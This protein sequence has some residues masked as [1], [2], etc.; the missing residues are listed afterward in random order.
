MGRRSSNATRA[1]PALTALALVATAGGIAGC[2][3]CSNGAKPTTD[4]AASSAS[5]AASV[6]ASA[7]WDGG[8]VNVTVLPAASIAK[9]VNPQNLPAYSGPTG[10]VEG[11][12][13]VIGDPPLATPDDF[14]K[15]PGAEQIWGHAFREG[16]PKSEGGPRPLADAVVAVTGYTGFYIPEKNEAKEVTIDGCGYTSRTVTT[17]LGQRVDVRNLAK[18]FWTPIL[19]PASRSVLRMA[20]PKGDPVA[21]YPKQP[22]HWFIVD[23]DRKY[24]IVDV[25]AFLHPLHT[26]TKLDGTYRIDGLP[27]GK[28]TV[29]TSHPRIA[30]DAKATIEVQAN[31]VARVDLQLV[32][33]TPDASA[34]EV[35]SGMNYPRVH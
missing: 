23:H 8:P 26:S 35:D 24:A 32:Y 15:C 9:F 10:S 16:P 7:P 34:P 22:G 3:G 13:T 31:V 19:E 1:L 11:T 17:T 18:D 30:N 6:T 4:A 12:I 5:A 14:H 21:L 29:N 33:R 27:I 25:Y 28:L 20:S 2:E